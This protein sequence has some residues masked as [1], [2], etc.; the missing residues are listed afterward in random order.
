MNAIVP[1]SLFR[2]ECRDTSLRMVTFVALCG[3][4][5]RIAPLTRQPS[6]VGDSQQRKIRLRFD[7]VIC[8]LEEPIQITACS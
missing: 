3:I 8:V 4:C 1:A 2:S 5:L 6:R 7:L